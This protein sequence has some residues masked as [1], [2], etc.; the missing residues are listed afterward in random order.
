MN[1]RNTETAPVAR[2]SGVSLRYG[3]T[4]ALNGI[5]LDIPARQMVG[6]IGPDGV[7]KSSLMSLVAGARAVQCGRVGAHY[8]ALHFR[9]GQQHRPRI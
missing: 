2:L 6:L 9:I 1:P 8:A 5:D 4:V 3:K 7:G